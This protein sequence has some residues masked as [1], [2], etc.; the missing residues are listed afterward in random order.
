MGSMIDEKKKKRLIK[1][2]ETSQTCISIIYLHCGYKSV[3]VATSQKTKDQHRSGRNPLS[4]RI[5]TD[6]INWPAGKAFVRGGDTSKPT[7]TLRIRILASSLHSPNTRTPKTTV[8]PL[9]ICLV[10]E[11]MTRLSDLMAVYDV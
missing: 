3:D 4:P 8:A 1:Y 6:E 2:E 7:P 11:T 9:E 10:T 5:R